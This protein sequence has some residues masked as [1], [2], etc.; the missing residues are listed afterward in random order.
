MLFSLIANY[1]YLLYNDANKFQ[2]DEYKWR[3]EMKN[4]KQLLIRLLIL[5]FMFSVSTTVISCGI[6][7]TIGLFGEVI[8]STVTEDKETEKADVRQIFVKSQYTRGENI[9]NIWYEVWICTICLILIFYMFRL[10]R[11]DTIVT[12]KVRMDD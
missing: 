4:K 11:E 5:L 2:F 10:P 3:L 8:S 6:I 12:L 1:L 7:N 9:Y